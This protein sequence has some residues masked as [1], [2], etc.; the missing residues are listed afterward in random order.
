MLQS[1]LCCCLVISFIS[2]ALHIKFMMLPSLAYK[3]GLHK[4]TCF[5][6]IIYIRDFNIIYDIWIIII[7]PLGQPFWI[8]MGCE[9]PQA[10]PYPSSR[11]DEFPTSSSRF[12]YLCISCFWGSGVRQNYVVWVLVGCRIKFCIQRAL[13]LKIWGK[14]QGYMLKI[15][16]KK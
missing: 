1:H 10:I 7:N 12:F 2:K 5:R 16:T 13:P 14:T 8:G 15:R 6:C 9:H 3:G 11:R 4:T